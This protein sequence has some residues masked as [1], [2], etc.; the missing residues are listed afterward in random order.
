MC[1]IFS[2]ATQPFHFIKPNVIRR[3]HRNHV[4][5]IHYSNWWRFN[6]FL[7]IQ[8]QNCFK[9]VNL[10]DKHFGKNQNKKKEHNQQ[11]SVQNV[12]KLSDYLNLIIPLIFIF[13][14]CRTQMI[15][16]N[17]VVT[18]QNLVGNHESQFV[19]LNTVYVYAYTCVCVCVCV[20][21]YNVYIYIYIY[22]FVHV[23]VCLC[24]WICPWY[25]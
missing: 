5:Q 13:L 21:L 18:I 10:T 15:I 4:S 20:N 1:S 17:L 7:E 22:I 11:F 23:C 16:K 3:L 25:L 2:K 8:K 9:W 12:K 19:N 14:S 24:V 6:I